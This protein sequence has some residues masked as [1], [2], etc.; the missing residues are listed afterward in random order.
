MNQPPIRRG[1]ER[2]DERGSPVRYIA[3]SVSLVGA[4]VAL[5]A[6]GLQMV[7]TLE[8]GGYGTSSIDYAL[9]LLGLGG[10]LLGL[11]IALLIWEISVRHHWRH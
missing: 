6:G 5:P 11:G 9:A 10:G 4:M 1:A 7:R 8:R 2:A 3:G